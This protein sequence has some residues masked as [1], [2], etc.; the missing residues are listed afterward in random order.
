MFTYVCKSIYIYIYFYTY[1]YCIGKDKSIYEYIYIE[2]ERERGRER[3]AT[4]SL[5]GIRFRPPGFEP[6]LASCSPAP[7]SPFGYEAKDPNLFTVCGSGG[8]VPQC[9]EDLNESLIWKN[10]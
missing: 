9:N 4:P 3:P 6:L 8:Y 1:M 7:P 5:A 2:R 10:L